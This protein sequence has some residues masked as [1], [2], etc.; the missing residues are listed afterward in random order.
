M[1]RLVRRFQELRREGRKAFIAYLTAGYPSL[2]KT[3]LCA[4][5]LERAGADALELG[6]P[7]SD[8]VA[9][10]PTIQFSSQKALE[11]GATLEKI[12]RL[13]ERLR[14]TSR[15]PVVLMSYLNPIHRRGYR[16]FARDARR[17]GVDGLI[18]PDL[19]PEEAGALRRALE[20]EG[21]AL[22]FLAAPTTPPRRRRMIAGRTRGFLYAVSLTGVTGARRAMPQD[23]V[24]FLRE[25]RN[26]SK[27]PV[28]VGFGISRPE[29]ARRFG[30][31]ADGVI[32]GSAFI[33]KLRRGRSLTPLARSLRRALD[34]V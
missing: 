11:K 14:R 3:L 27:S 18:V 26:V 25:L 20:A 13:V 34:A 16:T 12:L 31:L 9:D 1:N 29:Q 10:G 5:E 17:A 21:L 22:I 2:E 23:T 30:A 19:I 33:E 7:F 15:M 28:A 24:R 6:V 4:R 8:P 32:V